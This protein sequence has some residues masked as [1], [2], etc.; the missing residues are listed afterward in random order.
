VRGGDGVASEAVME[1]VDR[2]HV[3][4][5]QTVEERGLDQDEGLLPTER[6]PVRPTVRIEV[7]FFSLLP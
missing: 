1:D 7:G 2:V 5:C 4:G 6:P 3:H